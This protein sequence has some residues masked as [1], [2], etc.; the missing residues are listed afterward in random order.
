MIANG[1]GRADA[2]DDVHVG[3]ELRAILSTKL[4]GAERLFIEAVAGGG[5]FTFADLTALEQRLAAA[6]AEAGEAR[7]AASGVP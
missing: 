2:R 1:A 5:D 3:A 7:E 4:S 6:G